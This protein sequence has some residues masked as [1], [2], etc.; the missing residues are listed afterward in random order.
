MIN[1]LNN[2]SFTLVGLVRYDEAAD[3]PQQMALARQRGDLRQLGNAI[4][5]LGMARRR[6]GSAAPRAGFWVPA[7][8]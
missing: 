4:G 5:H 7:W 2:L 6:R 8:G 1:W 3:V